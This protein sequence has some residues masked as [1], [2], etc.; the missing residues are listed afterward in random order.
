MFT[1]RPNRPQFA[2]KND[3]KSDNL[4]FVAIDSFFLLKSK[5][6]GFIVGVFGA[7]DEGRL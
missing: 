6:P 5:K 1:F 7:L 2:V 3:L 4:I